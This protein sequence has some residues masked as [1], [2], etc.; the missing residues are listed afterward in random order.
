VRSAV[1]AAA[2]A[3]LGMV[4]VATFV[5]LAISLAIR[6]PCAPG[7]W[8]DGRQYRRLC[9]TD[10]VPLYAS[11][12]LTGGRL[13]YLDACTESPGQCDEYPVLTMYA[14]RLSAWMGEGFAGFF[15]A[16]AALL[17]LC[18]LA[19]SRRFR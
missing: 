12:Q 15:Y 19:V 10:I 13:P 6:R 1:R 5:A 17:A 11:E 18:A 7:D 9:Y 4:L 14:M 3:S 8:A 16:N 2:T